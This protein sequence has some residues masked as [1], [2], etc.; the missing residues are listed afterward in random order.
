MS[1]PRRSRKR[2]TSESI[3]VRLTPHFPPRAAAPTGTTGVTRTA[4]RPSAHICSR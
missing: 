3:L 1:S 2:L 4:E